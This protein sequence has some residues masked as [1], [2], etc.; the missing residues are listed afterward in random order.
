M[1]KEEK[2]EPQ[3]STRHRNE[4]EQAVT[5]KTAHGHIPKSPKTTN[6]A[7]KRKF[8]EH[9]PTKHNSKT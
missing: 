8:S 5:R 9:P 1:K 4:D 6:P 3:D 2:F 7:T